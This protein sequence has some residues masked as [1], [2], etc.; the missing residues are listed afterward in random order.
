MPYAFVIP[1]ENLDIYNRYLN[2]M[3]QLAKTYVKRTKPDASYYYRL[4]GYETLSGQPPVMLV[5]SYKSKGIIVLHTMDN[6]D[7]E[8][9]KKILRHFFKEN[10]TDSKFLVVCKRMYKAIWECSDGKFMDVELLT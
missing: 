7:D 6:L 4:M 8:D 1:Q 2:E 5:V 9:T 3:K 10:G